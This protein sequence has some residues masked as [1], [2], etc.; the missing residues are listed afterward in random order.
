MSFH[1]KARKDHSI[2][3]FKPFIMTRWKPKKTQYYSLNEG[4]RENFHTSF[5]RA[6]SQHGTL[7]PY[8]SLSGGQIMIQTTKQSFCFFRIVHSI[9][10]IP[11]ATTKLAHEK[12]ASLFFFFAF[13]GPSSR[14]APPTGPSHHARISHMQTTLS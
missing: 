2:S 8:F 5:Q 6:I 11:P 1:N 3:M 14:H 13:T 12:E 9:F 4:V 10:H 7:S